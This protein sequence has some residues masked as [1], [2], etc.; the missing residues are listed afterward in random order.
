MNWIKRLF[1]KKAE[2]KQCDIHVV[3]RSNIKT[4]CGGKYEINRAYSDL[5]D[6][7][8]IHITSVSI[9]RVDHDGGRGYVDN[10]MIAISYDYY[11]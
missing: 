11:A 2:T 10:Y 8:N 7:E 5:V 1:S 9:T 3:R 6:K 4:Y